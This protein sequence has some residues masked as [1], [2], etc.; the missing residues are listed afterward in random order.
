VGLKTEE[1]GIINLETGE[2]FPYKP[3]GK[4]DNKNVYALY[5][6]IRDTVLDY[7]VRN[8]SSSNIAEVKRSVALKSLRMTDREYT[9]AIK[10]LMKDNTCLRIGN[11]IYF[12]NPAIYL[13]TSRKQ[14]VKINSVYTQLKAQQ[15]KEIIGKSKN[16]I[17]PKQCAKKVNG[18]K[19]QILKIVNE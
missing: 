14:F 2:V 17:E 13:K 4:H 16:T 11:N 8:M 19:I 15:Q 10:N 7:L 9:A 12:L 1:Y 18:K 3:K 6:P 5:F